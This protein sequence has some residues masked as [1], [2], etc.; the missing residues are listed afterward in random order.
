MRFILSEAHNSFLL[1]LRCQNQLI[2]A[3]KPCRPPHRLGGGGGG[4]GGD[5]AFEIITVE[6]DALIP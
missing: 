1:Y 5:F 4:G 6:I 3:P 2:I